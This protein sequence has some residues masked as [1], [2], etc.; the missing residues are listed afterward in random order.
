[1]VYRR[2]QGGTRTHNRR[3]N[4]ALHCR[5]CYPTKRRSLGGG[6]GA[7]APPYL[8]SAFH[9]V[10]GTAVT[11]PFAARTAVPTA[12]LRERDSNPRLLGYEPSTLPLRHLAKPFYQLGDNLVKSEVVA[13]V[14]HPGPASPQSRSVGDYPIFSLP[15]I[16]RPEVDNRIRLC[17]IADVAQKLQVLFFVVTKEWCTTR[18]DVVD[19]QIVFRTACDAPVTIATFHTSA[20]FDWHRCLKYYRHLCFPFTQVLRAGIEPATFGLR[21]RC[22]TN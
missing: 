18:N 17:A 10:R 20:N 1:M 19:G 3:L 11:P 21:D 2:C 14:R 7:S 5:L 4:R 16:H 13:V 15:T 6:F 22:S 9:I 12:T 8:T